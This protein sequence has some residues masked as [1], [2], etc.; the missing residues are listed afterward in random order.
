MGEAA[1][2]LF[3]WFLIASVMAVFAYELLIT[4]WS[5]LLGRS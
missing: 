4:V 2:T 5:F 1:F 3:I